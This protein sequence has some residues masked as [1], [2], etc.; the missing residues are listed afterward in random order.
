MDFH[1]YTAASM[2]APQPESRD[3]TGLTT[4]NEVGI[5]VSVSPTK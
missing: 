1:F 4:F 2:V 3:V 5:I